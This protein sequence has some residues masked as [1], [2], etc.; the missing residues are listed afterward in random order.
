M[1]SKFEPVTVGDPVGGEVS[2]AF[3][4]S[5]K[6]NSYVMA[7]G[8]SLLLTDDR[9][10]NEVNCINLGIYFT[11]GGWIEYDRLKPPDEWDF[12]IDEN[13]KTSI[14][15]PI[16]SP[17]YTLREYPIAVATT[18]AIDTRIIPWG[19]IGFRGTNGHHSVRLHKLWFDDDPLNEFDADPFPINEQGNRIEYNMLPFHYYVSNIVIKDVGVSSSKEPKDYF[20]YDPTPDSQYHRPTFYFRL[21][22]EGDPN[23]YEYHIFIQP[24]GSSGFNH[25]VKDGAYAWIIGNI[26]A[27]VAIAEEWWGWKGVPR[28]DPEKDLKNSWTDKVD[29]GT[30]TFD[31]GVYESDGD[32][33]FY[34]WPYCMSVGEMRDSYLCPY[35]LPGRSLRA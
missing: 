8:A 31:I 23:D 10:P 17:S 3:V 18:F 7:D 12:F 6:P 25:L 30:Y 15:S 5:L 26:N 34:K 9:Y 35:Y 19:G 11:Q 14:G 4:V 28:G 32:W 27:P 22:D 13:G 1:S 2:L 29:W 16:H 21:E 24:T 20:K 33:F